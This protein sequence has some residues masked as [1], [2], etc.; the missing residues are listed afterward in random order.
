MQRN[1]LLKK[2]T[3]LDFVAVDLNLYLDTHPNDKVAIQEYN[4]VVQ[5][6]KLIR[7]DFEQHYGPLCSF[8]SQNTFDK[9]AWINNPWPWEKDFI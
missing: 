3:A 6:A 8:R 4:N 1:E 2:L 5:E 9:F 7:Q